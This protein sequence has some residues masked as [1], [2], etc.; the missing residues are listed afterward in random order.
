MP[1]ESSNPATVRAAA[2]PARAP[3]DLEQVN[4]PESNALLGG[5][6]MMLAGLLFA[7]M[8]GAIREAAATLHPFEVAFFRNAFGL[9]FMLPWFLSVGFAGLRTKHIGLYTV[10][11]ITGMLAMLA[12]F[13]A[14]AIMPLTEAVALSFTMPFFATILAVVFLG[15]VVRAR[16][17]TAIGVGFLGAMVILRPGTE[18]FTTEAMLVIF[19]ATMM[20]SSAIVIKMLSRTEKPAAIVAYM[21]IYLT[22]MSAIPLFFVWRTPTWVELGWCAAVGVL[23][24]LAHLALTRAFQAAD[25]SAVMPFD[26]SRLVFTAIIGYL[27]FDQV[28]DLWTWIGAGIIASSGIYIAHREAKAARDRRRRIE[29]PLVAAPRSEG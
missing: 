12:W 5:A 26:F 3:S 19:S 21:T 10:R 16:R 2:A 1:P 18:A 6:W 23:A 29:G 14:V 9:I 4:Q 15:E 22:P 8:L 11:G 17:W 24:T 27:F 13:W 7:A 20:A 25:T 28:S